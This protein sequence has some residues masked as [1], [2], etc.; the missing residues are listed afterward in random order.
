MGELQVKHGGK[1]ERDSGHELGGLGA[2]VGVDEM[3]AGKTV[4][5]AFA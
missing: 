2:E 4:T 5:E 3:D 1:R